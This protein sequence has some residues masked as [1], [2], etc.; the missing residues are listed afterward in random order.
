VPFVAGA[1]AGAAALDAVLVLRFSGLAVFLPEAAVEWTVDNIPGTLESTAIGLM[2]GY[3]KVL[4]LAVAVVAFVIAHAFFSLYYPRAETLLKSRWRTD[5]AFVAVPSFVILLVLLPLFGE[6]LAGERAP[7]GMAAAVFSTILGALV[8]AGALDLAIREIRTSHPE[9]LDVTRRT[10]LQATA[11]I[12]LVAV[13]AFAGLSTFVIRATRLA[14]GSVAELFGAEV[15]P[16][17][18]FYVVS[19][20]LDDPAV[21]PSTWS[22]TV[23]GLVD[24][25]LTLSSNELMARAAADEFVTLE[26]VSN[27][28]GGNLIGNAR[29]SG[30]SLAGLIDEAQPKPAATW[31]ILACADGYTVGVPLVR[32]RSLTSML[33]LNMNGERLPRR[34]GFPA[35]V[36]VPGLYGMFHAKWLTRIT[37]TDHEYLGYWQEKGWTNEGVIRPTAIIAVVPAGARRGEPASVGGVAL[38]GDRQIMRVE[39]SDDGGASWNA[40]ALKPP[41]APTAWTL[42]TYAWTPSASG[43][44]RLMARAWSQDGGAEESQ[45]SA[46]AGPYPVGASGYDS[47]QVT[48]S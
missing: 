23:D 15:T 22:L 41:L 35:R 43:S 24:A 5:A 30:V 26:C 11:A 17:D 39:V 37:L 32:A 18:S 21:N 33:A 10:L 9:G 20:N 8:Y 34:H 28:V 1:L 12:S 42:W 44:L 29:W 16:N 6:G 19:K 46:A 13:L 36:L 27:P 47:V 14:F 40:A 3:A 2:G 4:A 38:A 7:A 45:T 25:P 48:V 31:V